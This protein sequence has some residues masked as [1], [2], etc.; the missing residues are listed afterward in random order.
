MRGQPLRYAGLQLHGPGCGRSTRNVATVVTFDLRAVARAFRP[1]ILTRSG[2]S[3]RQRGGIR[4]FGLRSPRVLVRLAGRREDWR[5]ASEVPR[6]NRQA[7]H[8]RAGQTA[9]RTVHHRRQACRFRDGGGT[10]ATCGGNS[11]LSRGRVRCYSAH[12][13]TSSIYS[14]GMDVVPGRNPRPVPGRS[15]AGHVGSRGRQRQGTC[16]RSRNWRRHR[17]VV[18]RAAG[19]LRD[20]APA[21]ATQQCSCAAGRRDHPGTTQPTRWLHVGELTSGL[22]SQPSARLAS[23]ARW[24][25]RAIPYHAGLLREPGAGPS[26]LSAEGTAPAAPSSS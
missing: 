26:Q 18:P 1:G 12:T 10:G 11:E 22:V 6:P 16:W 14:S 20:L 21:P 19:R 4:A 13:G 7:G 5:Y 15:T 8:Y 23:Y 3:L 17:P 9:C 2:R 25:I 24:L